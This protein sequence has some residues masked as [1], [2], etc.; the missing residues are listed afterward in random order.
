MHILIIVTCDSIIHICFAQP[1]IISLLSQGLVLRARMGPVKKRVILPH[2]IKLGPILCHDKLT[3]TKY[4]FCC[5]SIFNC[6]V[7]YAEAPRRWFIHS[8]QS[9]S[10][11]RLTHSIYLLQLI[12]YTKRRE[13]TVHMV[14][15]PD[16]EEGITWGQLLLGDSRPTCTLGVWGRRNRREVSRYELPVK[17]IRMIPFPTH[18]QVTSHTRKRRSVRRKME[19]ISTAQ[20]TGW[21]TRHISRRC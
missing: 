7:K 17:Q 14:K 16:K 1:I 15:F 10:N 8:A 4:I 6:R 2:I 18:E 3:W 5:V 12:M 13:Y 20:S 19:Q 9:R 21:C 11:S